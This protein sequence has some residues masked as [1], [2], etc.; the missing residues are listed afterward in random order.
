MAVTDGRTTIGFI[1]LV[2]GRWHSAK[3]DGELV[4]I[5]CTQR[6]ASRALPIPETT[7]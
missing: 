3:A 5:Y 2:D 6:E 1:E 7:P 4:G